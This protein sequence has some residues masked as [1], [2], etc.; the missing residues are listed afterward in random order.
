MTIS[1]Q[2]LFTEPTLVEQIIMRG[3]GFAGGKE[4]VANLYKEE[5]TK[6]E[7]AGGIRREYGIMGGGSI[8]G[9]TW[10]HDAKGIKVSRP[11]GKTVINLSWDEVEEV[12]ERLVA[13]G[14][15]L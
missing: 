12:V 1:Q 6:D 14:R 4:R 3:T 13:E 11:D 8:S 15:Y 10:R 7:R 9:H 2:T 5:L